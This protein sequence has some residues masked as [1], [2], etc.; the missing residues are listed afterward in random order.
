MEVILYY[1]YYYFSHLH[2]SWQPLVEIL[3]FFSYSKLQKKHVFHVTTHEKSL[4]TSTIDTIGGG[5]AKAG[6]GFS[7]G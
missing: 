4:F 2:P 1:Y 3:Y 5:M 6:V 7:S